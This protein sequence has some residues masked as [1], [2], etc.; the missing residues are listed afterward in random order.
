MK[1]QPFA[2]IRAALKGKGFIIALVLSLGV[3][4]VSTYYAYN[5]IMSSFE[6]NADSD[7]LFM[8]VDKN[9]PN[10]PKETAVVT[11]SPEETTTA[12]AETTTPSETTEN[13]EGAGNFFSSKKPRQMPIEGE[14]IE[15]YSDGEL[16]KSK[17]LN[18]WQTHDGVD[19]AAA[20]GTEV[21]AAAEGTVL[22]IWEDPLWG[23][24]LS[25]DHGDGYI[26]TYC[27]LDQNLT[28]A[29]G[30]EIACGDVIGKVGKLPDCECS[31]APHLH[32]EVKKDGSF[33]NPVAFAQG[34]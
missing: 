26:S 18:L 24:S 4:G 1:K 16:V 7:N 19:I 14:I 8:E 25:I 13:A 20:E 6:E 30:Q 5:S 12:S 2:R 11:T 21:K 27:G 29:I 10:I 33:V 32:F 34:S 22:N 23:I 17:T 28:A 31:L 3:V 15:E 9:Q